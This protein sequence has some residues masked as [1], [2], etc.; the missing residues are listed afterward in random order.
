MQLFNKRN[1]GGNFKY[2]VKWKGR[3]KCERLWEKAKT[4]NSARVREYE[5][6]VKDL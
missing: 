3:P 5:I 2:L 1:L 4:L 6:K